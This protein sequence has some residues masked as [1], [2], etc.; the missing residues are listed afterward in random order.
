MIADP[1]RHSAGVREREV[2]WRQKP[3]EKF[4]QD[5]SRRFLFCRRTLYRIGESASALFS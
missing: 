2:A 5:G 4:A 3:V 1:L